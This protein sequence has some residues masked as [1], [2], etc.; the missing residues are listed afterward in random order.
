MLDELSYG[1]QY[2]SEWVIGFWAFGFISL[3]KSGWIKNVLL[4]KILFIIGILPVAA[5]LLFLLLPAAVVFLAPIGVIY[6]IFMIIGNCIDMRTK[7]KEKDKHNK[8]GVK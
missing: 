3:A 6:L 4:C 1:S 2:L 7:E 5:L 8:D